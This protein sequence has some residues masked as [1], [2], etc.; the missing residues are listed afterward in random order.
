WRK[1]IP[2]LRQSIS[3]RWSVSGTC[4]PGGCRTRGATSAR[5]KDFR[6]LAHV[7]APAPRAKRAL[8]SPA[9]GVVAGGE[10]CRRGYSRVRSISARLS[11]TTAVVSGDI[12]NSKVR[13][14]TGNRMTSKRSFFAVNLAVLAAFGAAKAQSQS[15]DTREIADFDERW[16]MEGLPDGRL[17]VTEQCC[18]L[19]RHDPSTGNACD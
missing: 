8:R 6:V 7:F 5:D 11:G 1:R 18:E 10:N 3:R 2:P 15:F 14:S 4:R 17:V 9:R 12:T 16:A 13:E 19:T